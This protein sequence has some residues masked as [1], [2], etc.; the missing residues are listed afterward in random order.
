MR[1]GL[2][3]HGATRKRFQFEISEKGSF[4]SASIKVIR[5]SNNYHLVTFWT[6]NIL[7]LNYLLLSQI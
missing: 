6:I 5:K 3:L 1:V 2:R 7:F 4:I